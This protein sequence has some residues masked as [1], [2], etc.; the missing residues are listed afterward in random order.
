MCC[1]HSSM[2]VQ[3]QR[4]RDS[5]PKPHGQSLQTRKSIPRWGNLIIE[6]KHAIDNSA[7][8]HTYPQLPS[9]VPA[10]QA[11]RGPMPRQWG[12]APLALQ[13]VSSPALPLLVVITRSNSPPTKAL[14][15]I[16]Y[17]PDAASQ[18]PRLSVIETTQGQRAASMFYSAPALCKAGNFGL[19]T[20]SNAT[21]CFT[22]G[23]RMTS[24]DTPCQ[25]QKLRFAAFEA[26]G[27]F[28]TCLQ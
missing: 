7:S 20:L 10:E 6:T 23:R 18:A 26:F 27:I 2:I 19:K 14:S 5:S 28:W 1:S 4:I 16:L 9:L 11:G 25:H 24:P 12:Q 15:C 17:Q 13:T 21:C 3:N 8:V 22:I